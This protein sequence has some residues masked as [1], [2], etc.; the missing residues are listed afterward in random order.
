M[1]ALSS[2]WCR[3]IKKKMKT[4]VWN[5]LT[6]DMVCVATF[7]NKVVWANKKTSHL[8]K[9]HKKNKRDFY[10]LNTFGCNLQIKGA[11]FQTNWIPE[12]HIEKKP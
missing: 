10:L 4:I 2:T 8:K 11:K 7:G 1:D 9:F 12:K 3:K 5:A 6:L